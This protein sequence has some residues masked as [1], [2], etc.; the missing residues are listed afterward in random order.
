MKRAE[1]GEKGGDAEMQGC[2]SSPALTPRSDLM[3]DRQRA[4]SAGVTSCCITELR[5]KVG[6]PTSLVGV[7]SNAVLPL[8]QGAG[9]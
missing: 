7:I 9:A 8:D 6:E 5:L 1:C 2:S 3:T 4:V